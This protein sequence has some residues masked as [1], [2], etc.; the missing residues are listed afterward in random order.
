[1]ADCKVNEGV[2]DRAEARSDLG[3]IG[4]PKCVITI[5]VERDDDVPGLGALGADETVEV[6]GVGVSNDAGN[7]GSRVIYTADGGSG[8]VN[9]ADVL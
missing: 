9:S 7:S 3:Q 2:A 6:L 8:D 1:M 5:S 4:K